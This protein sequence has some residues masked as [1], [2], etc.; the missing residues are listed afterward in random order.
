MRVHLPEAIGRETAALAACLLFAAA[1][2]L[3]SSAAAQPANDNYLQA[4]AVNPPGS[5]LPTS[6]T[7]TDDGAVNV[8]GATI[9]DD[10][11][12]ECVTCPVVPEG[13]G[14]AGTL[15]TCGRPGFDPVQYTH[16]VWWRAFPHR[17][18][19]L[20]VRVASAFTGVVG[21][22]PFD[23]STF[24]PNYGQGECNV[25]GTPGFVQLDYSHRLQEG[26]AYSIVVGGAGGPEGPYDVTFL[27][28][29]DTDR[30]GPVDSQDACRVQAG[31]ADL[32][33][34]PDSDGDKIRDLD[35]ECDSELGPALHRGCPDS[36]GDG[37]RN[38]DDACDLTSGSIGF[39]GCP[40]SDRDGLPEDPSG[41][42]KCPNLNPDSVDRSDR[43]PRDGCPDL[44]VIRASPGIQVGAYPGGVIVRSFTLKGVVKGAQVRLVCRLPGGG[45]C[46]GLNVRRASATSAETLAMAARTFRVKLKR[47]LPYGTRI[48]GS[49]KARYARSRYIRVSVVRTSSR[50]RCLAGPSPKKLRRCR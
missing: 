17:P 15:P 20:S 43:R 34:C 10:L 36:D 5:E 31:P 35:D 33:G 29:P 44:L 26:G 48:T 50:I 21:V 6:Q 49:V 41:S 40:D 39:G 12:Q 27:F 16:S 19:N 45:R 4:Y 32:G 14:G 8:I 1:A 28:D 13:A 25:A 2:A 22:L 23:V 9:Q 47:R 38:L 18:G 3:P 24:Q 11:L 7:F 30:D 42:D 46:G 37:I